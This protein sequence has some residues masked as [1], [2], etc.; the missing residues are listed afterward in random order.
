MARYLITIVTTSCLLL[1]LSACVTSTNPHDP[2]E[3]LNRKTHEFNRIADTYVA[4]P[5]AQGYQAITPKPVRVSVSNFFT[6]IGDVYSAASHLLVLDAAGFNKDVVRVLA[7]TSFGV[8]GLIDVAGMTGLKSDQKSLGDVFSDWGWQQSS[9]IVL[10]FLGPS[11]VRDSTGLALG[12]TIPGPEPLIYNTH[13]EAAAF[14][15]LR[16]VS[17]REKYLGY[18]ALLNNAALDEYAYLRD[19]Y[20]Q[21][22][23]QLTT[24]SSSQQDDFNIDDLVTE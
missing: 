6:N 24:R 23:N 15:G 10:P 18:E 13:E 3:S 20:L 14:Y 7:N 12:W 8:L 16:A 5:L 17:D 19:F 2:Y 22:K 11:T 1:S 21:S 9:Y 4:K